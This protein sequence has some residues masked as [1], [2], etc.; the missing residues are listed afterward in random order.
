MMINVRVKPASSER[1]I[2]KFGDNRFLI[3]LKSAPEHGDANAEL[4]NLLSKYFGVP[5][6]SIKIKAGLT[7]KDKIIEVK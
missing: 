4:I 6:G 5:I 3:Y 7:N 1:K 2:E